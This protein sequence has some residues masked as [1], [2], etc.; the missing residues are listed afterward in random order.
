M[1]KR[2]GM[3]RSRPRM[4]LGAEQPFALRIGEARVPFLLA[5]MA[6]TTIGLSRIAFFSFSKNGAAHCSASG[7][8]A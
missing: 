5:S 6:S 8:G 3:A 7:C 1:P 2:A 4:M